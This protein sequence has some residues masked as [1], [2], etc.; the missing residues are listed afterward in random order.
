MTVNQ[1]PMKKKLVFSSIKYLFTPPCFIDCGLKG[2]HKLTE[3]FS[4]LFCLAND[5]LLCLH[6]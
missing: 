4:S 5:S 6:E 2:S 1:S 3:T